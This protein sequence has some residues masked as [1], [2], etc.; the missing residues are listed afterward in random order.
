MAKKKVKKKPKRKAK[1]ATAR[2]KI[3]KKK[4]ARKKARKAAKKKL[5]KKAKRSA[6]R[7][8]VAKKKPARKKARKTAKK[9]LKKKAKRATARKKIAKKKTGKKL[10]KK[11]AKR[12]PV[13]KR[14]TKKKAAPKNE[15]ASWMRPIEGEPAFEEME[16]TALPDLDVGA[17]PVAAILHVPQEAEPEPAEPRPG[18]DVLE[19]PATTPRHANVPEA[20]PVVRAARLPSP[21]LVDMRPDGEA[22]INCIRRRGTPSRVHHVELFLDGEIQEELCRRYGIADDLD[23]GD[24]FFPQRRQ[25]AIQRFLGYDYVVAGPEGRGMQLNNLVAEDTAGLAHEGGRSFIDEHRG[26]IATMEEY[27]AYPW[28]DPEMMTTRALEWYERNLP[29][30]M[31]VIGGLCGHFAE[32]L[33]W[34]MGYETLCRALYE[35]RELVSAIARRT[36]LIDREV[37]KRLCQ[38]DRV[39]A[40]WG[41]DDMGHR[42]GT[43]ISPDD[44]REFVLPGHRILASFAHMHGRPY[45]LHSCGNLAE[46]MDDLIHNVRIDAKHSFED[47][48]EDVRDAKRRYGDSITLLGGIDVDFL[49]RADEDAVR[50]RVRSTL[51]TCVAGGGYCLG[52]GNSVANYIPID[53]YLAM[54]DEGRKFGR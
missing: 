19:A 6:T 1:R 26:P 25:I 5:K 50:M 41:S 44:L 10:K 16:G 42:S 43:L 33:S 9:K 11:T 36:L 54:I 4:P 45:L 27:E 39:K 23:P 12:K 37:V 47:T 24:E 29:D 2:E 17:E 15:G 20:A 28:P 40:I 48:I 30:D 18:L 53:N 46:I 32:N 7:K 38:F 13:K 34:L 49:C 31:C 22:F 21:F 52:T 8:K 35:D 3:A 14:A 51:S